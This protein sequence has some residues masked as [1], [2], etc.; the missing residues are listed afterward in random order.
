MNDFV[1]IKRLAFF[2]DKQTMLLIT[3]AKTQVGPT[4]YVSSYKKPKIIKHCIKTT[5]LARTFSENY[6]LIAV[7]RK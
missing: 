7:G 2:E 3:K 1:D 6:Q 5:Q 4:N